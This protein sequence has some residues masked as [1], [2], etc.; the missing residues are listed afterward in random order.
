MSEGLDGVIEF[1]EA[2]KKTAA[3]TRQIT[4]L[5]LAPLAEEV[6]KLGGP[7][8][9]E[10][11]ARKRSDPHM[12]F[13]ARQCFD[14]PE[15]LPIRIENA[16]AKRS[17]ASSL[18]LEFVVVGEAEEHGGDTIPPHLVWGFRL[19]GGADRQDAEAGA[20]RW[21]RSVMP[22]GENRVSILEIRRIPGSRGKSWV[23]HQLGREVF[24]DDLKT[25]FENLEDLVQ[26]AAQDITD[27]YKVLGD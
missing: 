17:P 23:R 15:K 27:L 10:K 13:L 25:E 24:K 16:L 8:P 1:L 4:A 22:N 11:S 5:L 20:Y 19:A 6:Q 18:R 26:V 3:S 2:N 21:M 12:Q 7:P 9:V 14:L